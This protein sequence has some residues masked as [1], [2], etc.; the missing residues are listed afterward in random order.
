MKI[1]LRIYWTLIKKYYFLKQL[2]CFNFA[3]WCGGIDYL[4]MTQNKTE[5]WSF[6][7]MWCIISST[8]AKSH[9]ITLV[10][11]DSFLLVYMNCTKKFH[12]NTSILVCHTPWSFYP[13]TCPFPFIPYPHSLSSYSFLHSITCLY[14]LVFSLFLPH[15]KE[16]MAYF[17]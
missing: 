4:F 11:F 6:D 17:Y 10:K 9:S 3:R 1:F 12:Y 16:S 2:L 7:C 13:I 15:M 14:I 5:W 8:N